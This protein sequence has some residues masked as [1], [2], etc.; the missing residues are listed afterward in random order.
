MHVSQ[1]ALNVSNKVLNPD[2]F[3][4]YRKIQFDS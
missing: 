1:T 4:G 3:D 2:E